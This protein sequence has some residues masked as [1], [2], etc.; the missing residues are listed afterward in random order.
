MKR[1]IVSFTVISFLVLLIFL[2]SGVN[3]G[4]EKQQNLGQEGLHSQADTD[5]SAAL[6][7]GY[8]PEPGTMAIIGIGALALIFQTRRKKISV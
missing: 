2:S 7:I 4:V 3:A 5:D 1:V 8:L 6:S